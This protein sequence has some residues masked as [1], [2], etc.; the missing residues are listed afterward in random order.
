MTLPRLY[1]HIG[2]HKT[3]STSLQGSLGE[4]R[5]VLRKNGIYYPPNSGKRPHKHTY[6]S[7]TTRSLNR[8]GP[9]DPDAV[10]ALLEPI[11]KG[12]DGAD[13]TVISDEAFSTRTPQQIRT[14]A[15]LRTYFDVRVVVAVRR[16]D[17]FLLSWYNQMVKERRVTKNFPKF[18]RDQPWQRLSYA[19]ALEPWAKAFGHDALRVL[20]F[21]RANKNPGRIHRALVDVTTEGRMTDALPERRWNQSYPSVM[22]ELLRQMKLKE[23]P[24]VETNEYITAFRRLSVQR[25]G[26]LT[27]PV[28]AKSYLTDGMR[29][30]ILE[31]FAEDNAILTETYFG[32]EDPFP[33]FNRDEIAAP[34]GADEPVFS[35]SEL[36]LAAL[37]MVRANSRRKKR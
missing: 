5:D 29:F 24:P 3:G 2:Y 26:A 8:D 21:D 27:H 18:V 34:N 25:G 9:A 28:F 1:L 30:E 16:Q 15:A 7:A 13:I 12:A 35:Q 37:E 19:K 31:R 20:S 22:I 11:A 6:L 33:G 10:R 17:T 4:E 14:L 23:D 32:G 36:A